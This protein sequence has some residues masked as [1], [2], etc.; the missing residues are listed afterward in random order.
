MD[1][2]DQLLTKMEVTDNLTK[3]LVAV[4]LVESQLVV[5]QLHLLTA[6]LVVNIHSLPLGAL[7]L[8]GLLAVGEAVLITTMSQELIILLVDTTVVEVE[9]QTKLGIVKVLQQSVE[10]ELLI[11]VA[12]AVVAV[13]V[14]VVVL[15]EAV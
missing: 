7:L 9:E 8:A 1:L 3:V 5:T 13:K 12:A 10:L 14:I 4:V 2:A 15:L 6:V 11:L